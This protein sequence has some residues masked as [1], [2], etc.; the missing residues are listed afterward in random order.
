MAKQ[1][2]QG[3]PGEEQSITPGGYAIIR[4]LTPSGHYSI[5]YRAEW[6]LKLISLG[7]SGFPRA[8]RQRTAKEAARIAHD[9]RIVTAAVH[10]ICIQVILTFLR[11]S[12]CVSCSSLRLY[13]VPVKQRQKPETMLGIESIEFHEL[14]PLSHA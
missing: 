6:P 9:C 5:V 3:F 14:E 11:K 8:I 2:V 7:Q 12:E 13:N 1:R 10:A 4:D